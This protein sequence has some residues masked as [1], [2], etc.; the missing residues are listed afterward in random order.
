MQDAYWGRRLAGGRRRAV[1]RVP[2]AGTCAP[3]PAFLDV[4]R[5]CGV[6]NVCDAACGFGAYGAMLA[7]NGF[8]VSLFD[9]ASSS[10]ELAKTLFSA[11]RAFRHRL[12][13]LRYLPDRLPERQFRRGR[14]PRGNR[15]SPGQTRADSTLRTDA[16]CKTRRTRVSFLRPAGRRR[17]SRAARHPSGRKFFLYRR[18]PQGAV[19]PPIFR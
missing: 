17:P 8:S 12:A 16:H 1:R 15:P 14:C 2:C 6:V 10:I 19:V 13:G 3:A 9:I 7:A 18:E 5:E 11:G 4:F